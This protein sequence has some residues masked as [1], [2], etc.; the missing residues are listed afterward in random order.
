M[1][2]KYL[3]IFS[4]PTVYIP[5]FSKQTLAR[6]CWLLARCCVNQ[7]ESKEEA[8]A[9]HG[10]CGTV[11]WGPTGGLLS[12]GNR[13]QRSRAVAVYPSPSWLHSI[14]LCVLHPPKAPGSA[15]LQ[16]PGSVWWVS[17]WAE[18]EVLPQP[19]FSGWLENTTITKTK[20][21]FK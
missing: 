10:G 6:G 7:S 21:L 11:P 3:T 2:L 12:R 1:M 9:G 14:S 18:R 19:S 5:L 4:F 17:Q 20:A 8:G 13:S 15:T 16:I